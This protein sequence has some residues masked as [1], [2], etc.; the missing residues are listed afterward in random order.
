MLIFNHLHFSF[1]FSSPHWPCTWY[2]I[3]LTAAAVITQLSPAAVWCTAVSCRR[4]NSLQCQSTGEGAGARGA[5][6]AQNPSII[7]IMCRRGAVYI[8]LLR[9]INIKLI[10][11]LWRRVF[12]LSQ[13]IYHCKIFFSSRDGVIAIL[14][15]ASKVDSGHEV[16]I[17]WWEWEPRPWAFRLG[18]PS[19][20]KNCIFW[21]I[22][23]ISLTPPPITLI[24]DNIQLRHF[25]KNL[26]LPPLNAIRTKNFLKWYF[27]WN[28]KIV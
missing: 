27:Q 19:K 3:V 9:I 14:S 24:W 20:K 11:K 28:F 18:K 25:R 21:D 16:L 4:L 5:W 7:T 12:R 6:Q 13:N 23:S 2:W 15:V 10:T 1:T 17:S 26:P 8:S 22:V